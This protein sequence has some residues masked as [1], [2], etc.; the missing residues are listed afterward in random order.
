MGLGDVSVHIRIRNLAAV[1]GG[2]KL[3]FS[4]QLSF[5][6]SDMPRVPLLVGSEFE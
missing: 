6:A 4:T 5:P 1:K 3:P 2:Q